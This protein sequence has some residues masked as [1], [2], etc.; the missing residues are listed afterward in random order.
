MTLVMYTVFSLR[1]QAMGTTTQNSKRVVDMLRRELLLVKDVGKIDTFG[2]R[3]EAIY[4]E[5]NRER[6]S[7]LGISPRDVIKELGQKNLV[8][9]SGRVKAGSKFITLSPTGEI[10]TIKQLGVFSDQHWKEGPKQI[11]LRDVANTRYGYVEPQDYM[12]RY[13]GMPAIGLGISTVSGGNVVSMGKA[14]EQ[15]VDELVA[16]IPIGINAGMISVQST[17]VE[18]AIRR[19]CS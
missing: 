2:E 16:Q 19:F 10:K 9:D 18:T 17:S 3:T 4:V 7:Q 8:T 14:L 5:T 13:D 1:L 15:R 6:M 11:Y 12:I